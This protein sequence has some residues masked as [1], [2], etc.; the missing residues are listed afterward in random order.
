MTAVN[1]FHIMLVHLLCD[2]HLHSVISWSDSKHVPL[3]FVKFWV[4]LEVVEASK[5]DKDHKNA[6]AGDLWSHIV[7]LLQLLLILLASE[8]HKNAGIRSGA[9]SWNGSTF[10]GIPISPK[11][12]LL[13]ELIHVGPLSLIS[14]TLISKFGNNVRID[15][16]ENLAFFGAKSLRIANIFSSFILWNDAKW[17]NCSQFA[18]WALHWNGPKWVGTHLALSSWVTKVT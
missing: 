3:N 17:L 6:E 15:P 12:R 1:L 10:I 8:T 4:A 18:I 2:F 13:C 9:L 16:Y 7:L 14:L 5:V 11:E